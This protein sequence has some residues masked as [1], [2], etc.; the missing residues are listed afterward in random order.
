VAATFARAEGWGLSKLN[1]FKSKAQ[2]TPE[3]PDFDLADYEQPQF[4]EPELDEPNADEPERDEPEFGEP[5][6]DEPQFDGAELDEPEARPAPAKPSAWRRFSSGTKTF[7]TRTGEVLNPF[8]GKP[9]KKAKPRP[10][11]G[12][13]GRSYSGVR[14]KK[15]E[16]KP[17]FFSGWMKPK[18]EPKKARTVT[19]FLDMPRPY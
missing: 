1:P 11:S 15:E 16:E 5:E 9:A 10:V 14:M 13:G 3:A 18:E 6:F 7:L 19:D 17:S 4:D 8:D 2:P 12:S